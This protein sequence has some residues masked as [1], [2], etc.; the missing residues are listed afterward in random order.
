MSF[1]SLDSSFVWEFNNFKNFRKIF[2][3]PNTMTIVRNT[4]IFVGVAI[5]ATVVLD[6]MFAVLTTYFIREDRYSSIF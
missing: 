3:D 5:C 6:L 2:L 4:C 1:T